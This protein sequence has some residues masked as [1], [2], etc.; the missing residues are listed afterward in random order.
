MQNPQD[1][2][3]SANSTLTKLLEV[4]SQLAVQEAGLLSQLK[5]VQEKRQSLQTV[6]SLFTPLDT[7]ATAPISS[8]TQTPPVKT[9][10]EPEPVGF[11]LAKKTVPSTVR[12]N[13]TTKFTRPTKATKTASGWQ[14]YVRQ[15]FS[16]ISLPSAVSLVLQREAEQVFDIPAV[17]ETIFE[18]ELPAEAESKARRQVTNILSDGARKKKWYRGQLGSYSMSKAAAKAKAS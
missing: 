17:V 7:P 1:F 16:H 11:D 6:V 12:R 9:G 18:D 3:Q 8:P 15:E 2:D 14:Q 5:S 4:D 13:Q 10:R